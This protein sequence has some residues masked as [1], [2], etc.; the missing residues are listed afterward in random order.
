MCLCLE[1][2]QVTADHGGVRYGQ[3]VGRARGLLNTLQCTRQLPASAIWG[4]SNQ[5]VNSTEAVKLYTTL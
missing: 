4:V 2:F 1:T 5:N 3:L